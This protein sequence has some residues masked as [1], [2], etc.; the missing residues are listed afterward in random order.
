MPHRKAKQIHDQIMQSNQILL[1]PHKNPDGDACGAV[2][3][4]GTYIKNY[5][6]K[7]DIFCVTPVPE[8]LR[9]LALMDEVTTDPR[10]WDTQY[11]TIIV[12]DSGDPEYAGVS[13]YLKKNNTATIVVI[14][15]HATNTHFG[16]IN[17]VSLTHSSTCELLYDYFTHN[18]IDITPD[19]ATALLCGI[20]YDTGSF[21][22]S[23]TS[24]RSLGIAGSLVKQGGSMKEV[25]ECLY[26][27]KHVHTLRLWGKAL[28][29]LHYDHELDI[30]SLSVSIEDMLS[31][32][33][34]EESADGIANFMN[35][36]KDGKIHIVFR[37]KPDNVVKVSMRTTRDDVDVSQIAKS[38][39]GGG[40]KKAAGFTIESPINSVYEKI[41]PTLNK[42]L[43]SV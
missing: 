24:K 22:N 17:L 41:L 1:I 15:H 8:Q 10:I 13:Q 31:C 25:I 27:N 18:R 19:M 21:T 29:N 2:S 37:E 11:D 20:I 34:D 16:D 35:T 39:G 36:L 26:N 43:K 3:A 9:G 40:H 4:L 7:V 6:K 38:F 12:C 33:V 23:A 14:D 5:Q 28:S 30:V 32:G 42:C